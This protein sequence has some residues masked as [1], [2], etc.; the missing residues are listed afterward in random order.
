MR[1]LHH[2]PRRDAADR[3]TAAFAPATVDP[4]PIAD[5]GHLPGPSQLC[6][7]IRATPS[8]R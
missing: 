3:L 2:V 4:R 7:E 1:Y 8:R 5:Q 6:A